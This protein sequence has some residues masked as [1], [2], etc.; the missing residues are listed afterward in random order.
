LLS[1]ARRAIQRIRYLIG[2]SQEH[3]Q[4]GSAICGDNPYKKAR[5]GYQFLLEQ[6]LPTLPWQKHF[7][8][9]VETTQHGALGASMPDFDPPWHTSGRPVFALMQ[10]QTLVPQQFGAALASL[11]AP[12]RN[13]AQVAIMIAIR[14]K[15]IYYP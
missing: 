2:S 8:G 10:L 12:P 13:T 6:K 15:R 5:D 7:P 14:I 4:I 3:K 9:W 11:S 1:A